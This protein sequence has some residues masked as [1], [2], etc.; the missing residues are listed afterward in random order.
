MENIISC[1]VCGEDISR[2]GGSHQIDG[3]KCT[4]CGNDFGM[5]KGY[6]HGGNFKP[7]SDVK[8]A[9]KEAKAKKEVKVEEAPKVEAVVEVPK[10][11]PVVETKVVEASP[12]PPAS[13]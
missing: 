1:D 6:L 7:L 5:C 2:C 12:V 11:A 10:E 9:K 13:E 4:V 8:A 3:V